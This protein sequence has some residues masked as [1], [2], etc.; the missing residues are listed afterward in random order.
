M[1][2]VL[3]KTYTL[4]FIWI[5]PVVHNFRVFIH[6]Y[7]R[8]SFWES[9][10]KTQ[11]LAYENKVGFA[12]LEYFGGSALNMIPYM[13]G[14]GGNPHFCLLQQIQNTPM[15]VGCPLTSVSSGCRFQSRR[16]D[17][18]VH[19]NSGSNPGSYLPPYTYPKSNLTHQQQL[20]INRARKK[21]AWEGGFKRGMWHYYVL[22]AK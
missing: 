22:L 2:I 20:P 14:G 10:K 5:K 19:F 18:A 15:W 13:G 1:N 9:V 11:N 8:K 16:K 3:P 4:S 12:W 6:K 7:S 21:V 17:A